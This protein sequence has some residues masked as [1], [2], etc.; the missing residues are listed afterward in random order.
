MSHQPGILEAIPTA[1]RYLFFRRR[2]GTSC[3]SALDTLAGLIL[4]D[5]VIAIGPSVIAECGATDR[6][7][8]I[9][10]FPSLEGASREVPATPLGVWCWLR[11]EDPGTL[12]HR[13]RALEA[14]MAP[15]FELERVVEGFRH[16][17]GRDLTG[18]VDGTENPEG[19][20]AVAAALLADAGEGLDGS[21][22]VAVQLWRHDFDAFSGYPEA[23]QDQMVGRR[24]ADDVELDDAPPS[25]HVK[26]TA[27]EDFDPEAFLIRRS[28]P[29]SAPDGAG[30]VFV[31]FGKSFDAFEAQLRRM[32]GL[33]D[34]VE[35]ALFRFTQPE[36]GSYAW[37]PPV[38]EG[39]LDLRA[40]R[41]GSA[42]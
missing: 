39:R 41:A 36:T 7:P 32:V 5:E 22:Y 14:A 8:G 3:S 17:E 23:E 30:L 35:D 21:S 4:D 6:V 11:G 28:M 42:R 38:R 18:Y 16:R 26:R 27:Q 25:A 31:A 12:L 37:C 9:R 19:D 2:A 20:E 24:K 33:D 29:W 10:E 40:L 1:A 15:G 34:G 13:G